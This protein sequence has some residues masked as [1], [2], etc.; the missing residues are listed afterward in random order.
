[1]GLTQAAYWTFAGGIGGL[2]ASTIRKTTVLALVKFGTL[3][4]AASIRDR[5][6]EVLVRVEAAA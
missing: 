5:R 3:T 2:V 4:A 1:M 6:P